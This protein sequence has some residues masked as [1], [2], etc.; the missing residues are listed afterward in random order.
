MWGMERV[1]LRPPSSLGASTPSMTKT[2]VPAHTRAHRRKRCGGWGGVGVRGR[3]GVRRTILRP[4][5]SKGAVH[6]PFT[7]PFH[8]PSPCLPPS[9][10]RAQ[11]PRRRA[12]VAPCRGCLSPTPRSPRSVTGGTRR[13]PDAFRRGSA[14]TSSFNFWERHKRYLVGHEGCS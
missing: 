4:P 8:L 9:S 13:A 7:P 12:G 6:D 1:G 10:N 5:P 11:A 14:S 3:G 2:R